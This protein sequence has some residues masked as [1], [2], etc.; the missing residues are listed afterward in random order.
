MEMSKTRLVKIIETG[1]D[2]F[3]NLILNGNKRDIEICR[4]NGAGF[5]I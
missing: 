3:S 1:G 5:W 2:F 4:Q